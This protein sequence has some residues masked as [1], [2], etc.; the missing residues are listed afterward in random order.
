[1]KQHRFNL[2]WYRQR[3]GGWFVE[4]K[5]LRLAVHIMWKAWSMDTDPDFSPE[6]SGLVVSWLDKEPQ[7]RSRVILRLA[8]TRKP[9][10]GKTVT[11]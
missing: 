6:E 3:N 10:D 9:N 1:M 2:A 4:I 8:R 5:I 7:Y 11:A